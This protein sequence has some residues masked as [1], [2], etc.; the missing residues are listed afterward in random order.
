VTKAKP[1]QLGR[2]V[3]NYLRD[4]REGV[5][6]GMVQLGQMEGFKGS[7]SDPKVVRAAAEKLAARA[8]ETTSVLVE[9]KLRERV[10]QLHEAAAMLDDVAHGQSSRD[11]FIEYGAQWADENGISYE[12]FREMGVP[13]DVLKQAGITR[14]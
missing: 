6:S 14:T 12:T 1:K 5:A 13:A 4:I 9:L 11:L 7:T 3:G 10:R 2:I 8:D